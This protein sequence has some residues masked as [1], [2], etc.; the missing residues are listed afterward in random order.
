M[1]LPLGIAIAT[2]D[3]WLPAKE[4]CPPTVATTTSTNDFRRSLRIIV[5]GL[6]R[7]LSKVGIDRKL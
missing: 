1:K 3:L 7:C 2:I 5:D 6:F 4:A